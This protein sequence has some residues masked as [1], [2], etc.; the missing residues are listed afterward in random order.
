MCELPGLKGTVNAAMGLKLVRFQPFCK[1]AYSQDTAQLY[2][3]CQISTGI[4]AYAVVQMGGVQVF[5]L[6]DHSVHCQQQR[7]GISASGNRHKEGVFQVGT[8][9]NKLLFNNIR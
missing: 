5:L 8:K 7:C 4:G 1:E 9:G 6:I 3:R 2:H